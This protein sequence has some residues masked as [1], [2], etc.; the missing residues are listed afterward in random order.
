MTDSTARDVRRALRRGTAVQV[1]ADVL[2]EEILAELLGSYKPEWLLGSEDEVLERL[3]VSRP[4]LR[5]AVRLLESEQLLIVR[6]GHGG[7]L[8]ARAPSPEGVHHAAA[9]FLRSRG[10]NVL[11]L[12]EAVALVAPM[13]M[14][15]AAANPDIE[16]KARLVALATELDDASETDSAARKFVQIRFEYFEL[17]A[18]LASNPVLSLY[19]GVVNDLIA[20]FRHPIYLGDDERRRAA[21]TF[22]NAANAIL[23]GDEVKAE[24]LAQTFFLDLT[25]WLRDEAKQQSD[26]NWLLIK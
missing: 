12:M 22:S 16:E 26:P 14:R 1:T 10:T 19:F 3:G 20:T 2:R 13:C 17:V 4:T 9:V 18:K 11:D 6:R 24:T 23:I 25:A 21:R 8:W 7:G 15:L 5:Q